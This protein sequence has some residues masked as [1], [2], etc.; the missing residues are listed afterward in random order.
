MRDL[1]A[2]VG[3]RAPSLYEYVAGKEQI[4]D[5]MFAEGNRALLAGSER[6][7][8]A[9]EVGTRTMLVA[10]AAGYLGFAAED[11]I[12]FQL[13]F[14]HAIT[15]WEPSPE[16]YAPAIAAY[17]VFRER[18]A[19][20]GVTDQA[21]LDLWTGLLSGLAHQQLANDPGGDRWSRLAERA[22]D[23]YLGHLAATGV[24][25]LANDPR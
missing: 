20:A 18:F 12:R 2:E 4:Y 11:P 19:E 6:L 8:R 14:Q 24:H 15:G 22:V 17:E 9:P 23:M 5:A 3:L 25:L 21:D 16:A 1:A 7:P 13:L 10:A